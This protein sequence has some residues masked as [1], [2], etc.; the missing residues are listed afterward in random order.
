MEIVIDIPPIF[1][2]VELVLNSGGRRARYFFLFKMRRCAEL[3]HNN[4]KIK[5]HPR[6]SSRKIFI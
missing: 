2:P 4:T 1:E 3:L 6:L 5:Q